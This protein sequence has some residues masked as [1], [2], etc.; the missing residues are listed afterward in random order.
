MRLSSLPV[1]CGW[2]AVSDHEDQPQ[3][4]RP[5]AWRIGSAAG[6]AERRQS[7]GGTGHY[8]TL[9]QQECKRRVW[10]PARGSENITRAEKAKAGVV[11]A[12]A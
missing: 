10:D 7:A 1:K 2:L 4:R 6:G 12:E 9:R 11:Y 8:R 5:S 3:T